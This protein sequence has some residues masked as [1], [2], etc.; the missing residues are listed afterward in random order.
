MQGMIVDLNSERV[1]IRFGTGVPVLLRTCDGFG[2]NGKGVILVPN[3]GESRV[4]RDQWPLPR[5]QVTDQCG[6]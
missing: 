5:A 4:I 2:G 6:F 3:R 1:G